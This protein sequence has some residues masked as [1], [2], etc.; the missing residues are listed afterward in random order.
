MYFAPF[1]SYSSILVKLSLLIGDVSFGVN[2]WT[3]DCKISP[4]STRNITLS[5]RA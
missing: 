5:C 4:Q 1:P 2:L 3:L